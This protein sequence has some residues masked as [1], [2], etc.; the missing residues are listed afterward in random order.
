MC[1]KKIRHIDSA[2]YIAISQCIMI[3]LGQ[4]INTFKS[5]TVPPLK[6][7]SYMQGRIQDFYNGVSISINILMLE[8][9]I[10]Y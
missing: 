3:F 7:S 5:C 2:L 1:L 4:C 10:A 9:S 6:F 8:S